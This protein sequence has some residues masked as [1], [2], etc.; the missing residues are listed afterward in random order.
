MAEKCVASAAALLWHAL[1]FT[2]ADEQRRHQ[3]L[4]Y[5][6]SPVQRMLLLLPSNKLFCAKGLRGRREY[7]CS[8]RPTAHTG[9]PSMLGA[10][11]CSVCCCCLNY[12]KFVLLT[13]EVF[14]SALGHK[15]GSVYLYVS[16]PPLLLTPEY[17]SDSW[18]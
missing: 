5:R 2:G 7:S 3:W 12:S 9:L 4:V 15:E 16:F 14:G 6:T 13:L 8:L 1:P 10:C 11:S 17:L 18:R